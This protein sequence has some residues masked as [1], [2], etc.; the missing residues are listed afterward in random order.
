MGKS[1]HWP[2]SGSQGWAGPGRLRSLEA[3]TLIGTRS[4][5]E[6]NQ[7]QSARQEPRELPS[8]TRPLPYPV[9]GT[10]KGRDH[11]SSF[12]AYAWEWSALTKYIWGTPFTRSL[13]TAHKSN[14]V[15]LKVSSESEPNGH[16]TLGRAGQLAS[17]K[18][19][20]VFKLF[21]LRNKHNINQGL[22]KGGKRNQTAPT[23]P[24]PWNGDHFS[25]T[26][27]LNCCHF[28]PGLGQHVSCL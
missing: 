17:S 14:K 7:L 4:L 2:P 10:G 26:R 1:K 3:G 12:Q 5:S 23:D 27:D 21:S 13:V 25:A 11:F 24:R 6:P 9:H 16:Q 28:S 19:T 8:A 20:V 22:E 18:A 15:R